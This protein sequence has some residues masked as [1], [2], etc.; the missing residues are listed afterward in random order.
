M[1]YDLQKIRADFPIL[2]RQVHGKPLV[3]LDN[4][5]TTQ[6]PQAMLDALTGF[7]TQKNANIHRG[8]HGLGAEATAAY[9]QARGVVERFIGANSG[10]ELVFTRNT[11]ESINLVAQ[12]WGRK[13]I[14]AGDE[15]V[16]TQAEHH[17]NFVPWWM[18]AQATGA[19]LR[20]L[21]L[22]PDGR[23]DIEA[24]KKTFSAKTKI[25][26]FGWISNVLGAIN[27]AKELTALAKAHGAMVLIDA[28]QAVPHFAL[29]VKELGADFVA[30][31]AHKMLGPTGVGCLWGEERVLAAMDPWQGGGSMIS[32][33]SAEQVTWNRLPWKF[34][35]GTPNIADVAAFAASAQY[36]KGL[37]WEA[38]QAHEASLIAHALPRLKAV[39]GLRL[40]GPQGAEGR[41]GVFSFNLDGVDAGDCGQILDSLGI[42][43]R[44]GNHCAQ[45]LMSQLGCA[46]T[47][48]ASTYIYNTTA[49]ID[50]LI[51]GLLRAQ[52]MLGKS[53]AKAQA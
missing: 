50:A 28:A 4:A 16:L 44:A 41:V 14:K 22:D 36:L 11:T 40:H 26:A 10:N 25:F 34:E 30:F 15:I 6:K 31:S 38:M 46:G 17:A 48:R 18:L 9:E 20:L 43:V 52:K 3:Y 12:A 13:N 23:I 24:A 32:T 1:A 5:A 47:V 51:D 2:A 45:P 7:Y 21:P 29:N 27:P 33:V 42:E 53:A 35:A 49:E 39:P 8:A 19:K 37:G